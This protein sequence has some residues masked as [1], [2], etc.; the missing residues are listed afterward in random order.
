MRWKGKR[1]LKVYKPHS[2]RLVREKFVTFIFQ[3]PEKTSPFMAKRDV[4]Q[5]RIR[6]RRKSGMNN[7]NTP[8][9]RNSGLQAAEFHNV[10]HEELIRFKRLTKLL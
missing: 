4:R 10:K 1:K 9:K 2:A 5:R 3:M 8:I 7:I 6:L